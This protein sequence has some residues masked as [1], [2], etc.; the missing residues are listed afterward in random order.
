VVSEELLERMRALPGVR[1]ASASRLTPIGSSGWNNYVEVDGFS[2]ADRQ[3]TL[4]WFNTVSDA[5]FATLETP[6]Q[7]GRDFDSRD[8]MGGVQVAIINETMARRFFGSPQPLGSQFRVTH[9]GQD[10]QTYEVVG[11]VADTKYESVDEET[12]PIAYFPFTQ[13]RD[14]WGTLRIQLRTAGE[15][16]ALISTVTSSITD[17]HPRIS[18]RF[19]TLADDVAASLTRPR[20]LA[21]LSGFFGGVA[22]LLAMIGLYGTL[23][24][25][26]SSRRNEIGV[27]LALG[28]ARV[29]VL[30]MV[31][32]EVGR[33]TLLGVVLGVAGA[34]ASTRL[35]ASFLFGVEATDP[36]TLAIS[37]AALSVVALIAGALPAWHAAR[38]N[39]ME[40]L[41]EE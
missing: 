29:G 15:P 11:V 18:V 36:A 25:R 8:V 1:S 16:T 4:A 6:I 26:V 33:M 7:A 31:L 5:Y 14:P 20:I 37:A 38:L 34:I 41:R 2:P 17:V 27:R 24:Y 32:A 23:S 40:T 28:A 30:G 10:I 35:L 21:V 19:S 22:L 13:E 12:A 3:E 39:P 9:P